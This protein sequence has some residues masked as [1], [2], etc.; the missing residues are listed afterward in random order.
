MPPVKP[1]S[2]KIEIE[3][4]PQGAIPQKNYSLSEIPWPGLYI[5]YS[6]HYSSTAQRPQFKF[7]KISKYFIEHILYYTKCLKRLVEK[8]KVVIM[9]MMSHD[10]L[11]NSKYMIA[12]IQITNTQIFILMAVL[13][14]KLLR[15]D[16]IL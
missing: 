11:Y 15:K 12:L 1:H 14:F 4:P 16:N 9:T 13:I 6:P 2:L 7:S 10:L 3:P 5:R 8:K